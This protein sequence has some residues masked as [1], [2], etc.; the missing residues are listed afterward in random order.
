MPRDADPH[1]MEPDTNVTP[2]PQAAAPATKAERIQALDATRGFAVLG[3]LLMNI[4]S[5]AGPHEISE[6]PSI[7]ASWGGAPLQ[8]WAVIHTLFEGSQRAL[9]SMLFGAGMLLLVSRLQAG[10]AD[11]PVAR[12]YYR[13]LLLLM[14]FGLFDAFVLMWA[15]DIL[16]IYALCGLLLYPLRRLGT[17]TLLVCA[18]IVFAIP[19]TLR[20]ID[21]QESMALQTEYAAWQAGPE[22]G[23]PEDATPERI[24]AWEV[25]LKRARPDLAD[26][27]VQESIRI[28]REGALGEFIVE[29]VRVSLIL[30]IVVGLKSWFLDALGAML[31]GMALFRS[32]VLTLR[33]PQSTYVA[34]AVAGYCIG[35]PIAAWETTALIATDFDPILKARNLIHYDLRRIAVGLGHLG[36]ILLLCRA[37]PASGFVTRIAAVGRMALSNYLGQSILCGLLFST[38]GL[39]WYGRFTGYYLY[40]VVAGVWTLQILFSHWWLTRFRFGPFEW[41]WR[42]LTYGKR[43]ALRIGADTRTR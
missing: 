14:G 15:A 27:D 17:R 37:L 5:F 22:A 16:I 9:F 32:G 24:R 2:A 8:T 1:I 36:T 31:I 7:A 3:I 41:I 20:T 28:N 4:W 38:I 26:P 23:A 39:G 21:W 34:L 35:L 40:I 13:R 18:V 30:Q 6:Y 33:A 10:A 29:R 43:Q 12:I 11:T 25:K 19:A 42:S